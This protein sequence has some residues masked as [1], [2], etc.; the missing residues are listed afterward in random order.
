MTNVHLK[1]VT[2][3]AA[4]AVIKNMVID[5]S[6]SEFNLVRDCN[7][8]DDQHAVYVQCLSFFLGWVPKEIN[9]GLKN[10]IW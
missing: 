2:L 4:Q 5:G 8:K 10:K 6:I 9:T 1:G 3:A 7:N